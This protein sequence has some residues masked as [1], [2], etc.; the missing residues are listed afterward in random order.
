MLGGHAYL[1]L[2]RLLRLQ[3]LYQWRHLDRFGACAENKK[4]FFVNLNTTRRPLPLQN[5]RSLCLWQTG[6]VFRLARAI[7]WPDRDLSTDCSAD[8]QAHNSQSFCS[9][10]RPNYSAPK[11]PVQRPETTT[12][13]DRTSSNLHNQWCRTRYYNQ[14]Q[15]ALNPAISS[16]GAAHFMATAATCFIFLSR[17]NLYRQCLSCRRFWLALRARAAEAC[18]GRAIRLFV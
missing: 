8:I 14:N 13:E 18:I 5:F 10:N 11:I 6:K 1:D 7:Y 4:N 12:N 9:R 17:L 15:A 3:C 16:I 2:K